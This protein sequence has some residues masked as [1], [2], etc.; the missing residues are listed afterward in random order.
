MENLNRLHLSFFVTH[1]HP[2][3]LLS[4]LALS[5]LKNQIVVPLTGN[6][7]VFTLGFEVQ[8][9]PGTLQFAKN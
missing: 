9:H 2:P 3:L 8:R 7:I 1:L 4:L 6:A 5:F